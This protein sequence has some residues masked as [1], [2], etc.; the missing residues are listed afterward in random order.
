MRDRQRVPAPRQLDP[1]LA[2]GGAH[3]GGV[4]H[5]QPAMLQPLV[6]D[7]AHQLEGVGADRLVGLVVGDQAAAMVRR[8]H[9]GRQEMLRRKG[10]LARAGRADQHDQREIGDFD[11]E[12]VGRRSSREHR[13]LRRRAERLVDRADVA[14]RG[15]IAERRS[16]RHR[17]QC[18]ELRRAS[19]RS[20]GRDGGSAGREIGKQGVVFGVRRGHDHGRGPRLA[21]HHRSQRGQP[22]GIEVLDHLDQRGGVDARPARCRDR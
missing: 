21:E 3:I 13:H 10:R 18:A 19:I 8:D 17:A 22:V 4:D 16:R 20:G 15:A 7:G 1:A 14:E 11:V 6:G 12:F 5:G 2:V 9:L